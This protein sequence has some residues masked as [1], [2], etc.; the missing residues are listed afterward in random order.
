MPSAQAANLETRPQPRGDSIAR[1]PRKA[2]VGIKK[3]SSKPR[4][5]LDGFWHNASRYFK[6]LGLGWERLTQ[7]D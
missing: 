4:V 7:E 3:P 1:W 6:G 2:E 5:R